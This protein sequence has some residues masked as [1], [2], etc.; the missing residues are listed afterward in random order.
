MLGGAVQPL[1]WMPYLALQ[2]ACGFA[3]GGTRVAVMDA[4]IA[5]LGSRV[6]LLDDLHWADPDTLEILPEL[7]H[8]VARSS[9]PSAPTTP[10]P[11][12]AL[13]IPASLGTRFE[14]E[15]L[16]GDAARDARR[17]HVAPAATDAELRVLVEPG[18]AGIRCCSPARPAGNAEPTT[19]WSPWWRA[20]SPKAATRSPAWR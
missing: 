10:T 2:R 15:P 14:I 17:W 20:W 11:G 8:E 1:R 5:A 12:P 19:G 4:A 16:C 3:L 18:A 13:A 7:A 9:R 6:L